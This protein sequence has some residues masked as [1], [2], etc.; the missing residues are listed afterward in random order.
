MSIASEISRLQ[1]AKAGPTYRERLEADP[2]CKLTSE[3]LDEIFDPW[4]FLTRKD[5][6]FKRLEAME[7]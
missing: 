1:Q 2:D 6:I 5:E 7:F 4:A 3:Q